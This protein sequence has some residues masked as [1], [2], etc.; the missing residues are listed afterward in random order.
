MSKTLRKALCG[1]AVSLVALTAAGAVQAAVPTLTG[2]LT[3]D[4][5]FWAYLS[6]SDAALGTLIGQGNN[7]QAT[8]SLT[9]TALS[10]ST[11]YLHVVT[12]DYGRPDMFI[13]SFSLTGP[14][15][16]A[17]STTSL[18]TNATD[19]R[20]GGGAANASWS[21]PSGTPNDLGVNGTGP[22]GNV[23]GVSASARF[24]WNSPD[25]DRAFFST[26]ITGPRDTDAVPEP[27]AWALMITG[28]GLAGATL[29][30]RRAAI[31]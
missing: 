29:R 23:A 5:E 13:G 26:T 18:N 17:N 3:S 2:S 8:Y 27:A 11:Y 14:Y 19:W 1:V 10:A 6:T 24:I 22:W 7:W 31:A 25:T 12:N 20:A 30:R 16:F 21:A 15:L 9:P 4:N 28:F